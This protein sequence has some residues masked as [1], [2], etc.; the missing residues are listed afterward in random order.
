[1]RELYLKLIREAQHSIFIEN[2]YFYHPAIVEALCEAKR[3]RPGLD[4]T[5]VVPAKTWNDNAFA[6]DA[7][8]HEYARYL[9]V[10]IDVYEYQCHFNHLKLAVFDA[11]WSIHGST[12]GNFRS[13]EDDKDF[14]LVVLVDDEPFGTFSPRR[15]AG[16]RHR[17]READH[18]GRPG[19]SMEGFRIRHAIRE[20]CCWTRGASCERS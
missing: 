5:L 8:Q 6:L 4:V 10:G 1:M 16:R 13:L 20:R 11:R 7:Q 17:A 19:N 18:E 3:A 2:P 9:E 14:E 12:N 15:R